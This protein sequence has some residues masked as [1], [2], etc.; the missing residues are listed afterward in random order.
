[1]RLDPALESVREET[2]LNELAR[3]LAIEAD[4]AQE[5]LRQGKVSSNGQR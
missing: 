5:Q 3:R 4:A 2:R 1:L